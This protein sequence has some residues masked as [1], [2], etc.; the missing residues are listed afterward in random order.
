MAIYYPRFSLDLTV[1]TGGSTAQKKIQA[2]DSSVVRWT[3]PVRRFRLE[4]NDYAMADVLEVTVDWSVAGIDPRLIESAVGEFSIGQ[5]SSTDPTSTWTPSPA[6]LRFVGIMQKPSRLW[7]KSAREATLLFHDYTSIFIQEKPFVTKGIPDYTQ[8]LSQAWARICDHVGPTDPDNG[9]QTASVIGAHLRNDIVFLGEATDATLGDSVGARFRG[10][11]IGASGPTDAWAIWQQ[12]VQ[13]AGLISFVELGHLVITT[14][15]DYYTSKNPGRLIAGRNI[16]ELE[17]ERDLP[18]SRSGIIL[19]SFDP[20]SG[21]TIEAF[22]PPLGDS[23]VRKKHLSTKKPK[24]EDQIV[25]AEARE[26]F[27]YP[28]IT[29]PGRLQVLAD[30][31]QAERQ[32]QE[33]AGRVT[34]AEM[35][36]PA[37]DGTDYD[38]LG[39]SAGDVI[40]IEIEADLLKQVLDMTSTWGSGT[41]ARV[42]FLM[43]HGY[44]EGPARVLVANIEDFA[45]LGTKFFVKGVIIECD[46]TAKTF[47]VTV[48]YCN[49]IQITGDADDEAA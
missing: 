26:V 17:E 39:L 19:Y 9:N 37:L 43:S 31:V 30:R 23:S 8:T 33:L 21:T 7:S 28:G 2:T 40:S 42:A 6:E 14:A 45:K 4:K 24:T 36:I 48:H 47:R 5:R 15:T 11:K 16:D 1:T 49:R 32:V 20:M 12:C 3:M 34:T 18:R 35:T 13:M 46:V 38:L 27:E 25:K 10:D 41:D 29:D 22:S 44:A